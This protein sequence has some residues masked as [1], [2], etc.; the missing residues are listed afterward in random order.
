MDYTSSISL[1]E[2]ELNHN[3]KEIFFQPILATPYYHKLVI[4]RLY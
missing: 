2:V 1:L 3:L 4:F